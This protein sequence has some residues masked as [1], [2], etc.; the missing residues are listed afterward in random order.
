MIQ[1]WTFSPSPLVNPRQRRRR[2]WR[3]HAGDPPIATPRGTY[4]TFDS[5]YAQRWLRW[6]QRQPPY[7]Q[8]VIVWRW[9]RGDADS[10]TELITGEQPTTQSI[11]SPPAEVLSRFVVITRSSKASYAPKFESRRNFS[12]AIDPG[13][14]DLPSGAAAATCFIVPGQQRVRE[15]H[16]QPPSW[17]STSGRLL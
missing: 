17:P 1:R 15:D 3:G 2:P 6:T 11:Q 8:S 7:L 4:H 16:N 14:H 10:S 12:L 13:K 9:P 5:L